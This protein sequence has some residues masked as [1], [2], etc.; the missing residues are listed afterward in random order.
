MAHGGGTGQ[1]GAAR[2]PHVG[3]GAGSLPG[4]LGLGRALCGQGL[5]G[6][7]GVQATS[8]RARCPSLSRSAP[9]VPE[10]S[11]LCQ[12]LLGAGAGAWSTGSRMG[13]LAQAACAEQS[14]GWCQGG[15]LPWGPQACSL[16]AVLRTWGCQPGTCVTFLAAVPWSLEEPLDLQEA[17]GM[18]C[19][20][21][22]CHPQP[23]CSPGLSLF[24]CSLQGTQ[25]IFNA[26]KELGQLSKLKVRAGGLG[27]GSLS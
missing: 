4:L 12:A 11:L 6:A 21:W 20:A 7:C 17:S 26:A 8:P 2:V 27:W 23:G 3:E 10:W 19:P 24:L 22:P 18:M 13:L 9:A 25:M 14:Q 1:A 16:T 5:S 15:V